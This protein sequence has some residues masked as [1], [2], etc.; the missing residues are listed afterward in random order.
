MYALSVADSTVPYIAVGKHSINMLNAVSSDNRRFGDTT[1]GSIT[2]TH[3]FQGACDDLELTRESA[4]ATT[5]R[6][7]KEEA[8]LVVPFATSEFRKRNWPSAS[9]GRM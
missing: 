9:E 1:R 6:K 2:V 7:G 4:S 8:T 5:G 3:G